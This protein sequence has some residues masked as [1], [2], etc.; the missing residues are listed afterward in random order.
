[1]KSTA[2]A[3]QGNYGIGVSKSVRILDGQWFHVGRSLFTRSVTWC[4]ETSCLFRLPAAG[5]AY[6]YR[7][8]LDVRQ[9]GYWRNPGIQWNRI[10]GEYSYM[11][12]GG[13]WVVVPGSPP[14]LRDDG[15]HRLWFRV[16]FERGVYLAAGADSVPFEIGGEPHFITPW[17][18]PEYSEVIVGLHL[19]YTGFAGMSVDEVLVKESE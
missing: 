9:G 5:A 13:H 4:L 11:D 6:G 7:L 10:T 19:P 16:E 1:M 3:Y 14:G 12:S 17:A 8:M 2:H 15:W 18:W